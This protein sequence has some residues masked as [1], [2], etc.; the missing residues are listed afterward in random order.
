M[1]DKSKE[2]ERLIIFVESKAQNE[3][4]TMEREINDVGHSDIVE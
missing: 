4:R 1:K 3:F 2:E